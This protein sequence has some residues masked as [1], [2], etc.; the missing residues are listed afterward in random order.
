L[1]SQTPT[2]TGKR[3][4]RDTTEDDGL[5]ATIEVFSGLHVNENAEVLDDDADSVF[6]EKVNFKN[7]VFKM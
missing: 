6:R 3:T 4:K 5:P 2:C 7:K 1:L